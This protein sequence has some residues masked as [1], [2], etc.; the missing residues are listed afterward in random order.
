MIITDKE[1]IE[2]AINKNF[3]TLEDKIDNISKNIG[4]EN[5][6]E[7]IQLPLYHGIRTNKTPEQIRKEGFCKYGTKVDMKNEIM[8][9]L[10][11]FGKEKLATIEK[12]K[13]YLVQSM[14]REISYKGRR[15]IWTTTSKKAGCMWWAH[16]SP[17]H[18][19]LLLGQID[20]EPEKID[21]YLSERYGKHCYNIKLKITSLG[22]NPNFNTGLDC[23]PPNFIDTIEEC[24]D[25]KYTG[26]EHK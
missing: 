19:S 25:C 24:N 6:D 26:K 13:G 23:I 4:I 20:I 7:E 18:I 14:L 8:S 15:N 5:E 3:N 12:G 22:S 17:E 11:Y 16:A 1:L 21:K 2:K 10:R 9:A